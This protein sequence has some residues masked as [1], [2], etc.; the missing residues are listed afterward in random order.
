MTDPYINNLLAKNEKINM[1]T[2]QHWLVLVQQILPEILVTLG[3]LILMTIVWVQWIPFSSSAWGYLI[4]LIPIISMIR[5]IMVW[6]N[7]KY[8]VTSRRVIQVFGV[9][10]KNVTDSS[11]EKVNDVKMEQTMSGRMFD[12]GNIEILTAS[13]LGVNRFAKIW[14][15]IMF[16]KVMLDAKEDIKNLS[17]TAP[18]TVS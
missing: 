2:R 5:D 9:F 15:P 8:V 6:R 4:I 7:H 1:V 18:E 12:Y 3:I 16:K 10:T 14:K 13:E 11:L 17:T